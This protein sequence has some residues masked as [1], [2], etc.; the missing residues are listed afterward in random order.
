MSW[1]EINAAIGQLVYLLCVLAH[2]LGYKFEK[3]NLHVNG[4]FSKI[5]LNS[6]NNKDKKYDLFYGASEE[7]F[8]VGLTYLTICV[9]DFMDA[10]REEEKLLVSEKEKVKKCVI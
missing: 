2:R 5:S 6:I 8:N 1:D 9:S 10:L 4:A 3:F 7:K